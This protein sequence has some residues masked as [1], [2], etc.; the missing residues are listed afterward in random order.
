MDMEPATKNNATMG[1]K[2]EEKP[3]LSQQDE[4]AHTVRLRQL[5]AAVD[6]C[7]QVVPRNFLAGVH[8]CCIFRNEFR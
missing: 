1:Q 8:T 4:A 5:A 2:Q 6:S 3:D 7:R